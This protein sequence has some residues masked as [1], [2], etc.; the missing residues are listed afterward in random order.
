MDKQ[1]HPLKKEHFEVLL[2]D[3]NRKIDLLVEGHTGLTD[4]MDRLEASFNKKIEERTSELMTEIRGVDKRAE[5]RD[6]ELAMKTQG[7]DQRIEE[8][9]E[10]LRGEI[11]GVKKELG[12]KIEKLDEKVSRGLKRLDRH[13][14]RITHLAEKVNS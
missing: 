5:K 12:Q 8:R 14:E 2:E 1:R 7:L 10:G 3:M 11:Q 6:N 4:R 9:T 13:E